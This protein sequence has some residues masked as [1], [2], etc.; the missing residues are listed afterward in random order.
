MAPVLKLAAALAVGAAQLCNAMTV[1]FSHETQ[2][3]V[4]FNRETLIKNAAKI[5]IKAQCGTPG[6]KATDPKTKLG[7]AVLHNDF[8]NDFGLVL[9]DQPSNVK[10]YCCA[11]GTPLTDDFECVNGLVIRKTAKD[12]IM[13]GVVEC[14][15]MGIDEEVASDKIDRSGYWYSVVLPCNDQQVY[16]GQFVFESDT[17]FLPAE[18]HPLLVAHGVLSLVYLAVALVWFVLMGC[19]WQDILKLQYWISAVLLLSMLQM[20]M[21]YGWYEYS[22]S[23]GVASKPLLGLA[24]FFMV[25]KLTISRMLVLIVA[26]GYGVVKPSLGTEM[27]KVIAFGVVYFTCALIYWEALYMQQAHVLGLSQ[28]EEDRLLKVELLTVFPLSLLDAFVVVW[29]LQTLYGTMRQLKTRNKVVKYNMYRTFF[30]VLVSAVVIAV[31]CMVIQ[32]MI[33][34]PAVRLENWQY[35]WFES[36]AWKV[37]FAYILLAIMVLWRPN[38]NNKR[39]AYTPL[40]VDDEED[41]QNA[42]PTA[43]GDMV[44]MRN[45]SSASSRANGNGAAHGEDDADLNWADENIPATSS[46][47]DM[48]FDDEEERRAHRLELSKMQ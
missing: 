15:N 35:R 18:Q 13:G 48:L 37:I 25:T 17:G 22:N 5:S 43:Y 42:V 32:V 38:A 10:A 30:V 4:N 8:Y 47:N 16:H 39:F 41:M 29:I 45:V 6:E 9:P 14:T 21:F 40:E 19:Y 2:N 28:A 3:S 34:R 33:S 46:T 20:A 23:H 31:C 7:W 12:H 11:P 27:R 36:V 26:M 44:K 1:T 24:V